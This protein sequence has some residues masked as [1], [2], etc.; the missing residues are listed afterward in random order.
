M[1]DTTISHLNMHI[2]YRLYY[3]F[4]IILYRVKLYI[5]YYIFHPHLLYIYTK[6]FYIFNT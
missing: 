1:P 4:C 5:T 2:F 6:I 3:I